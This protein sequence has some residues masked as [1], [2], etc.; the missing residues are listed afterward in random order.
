[1]LLGLLLLGY[2]DDNEVCF[3]EVMGRRISDE[4]LLHE[5]ELLLMVTNMVDV[6]QWR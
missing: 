3:L 1:M 5:T 4:A 2:F 6:M